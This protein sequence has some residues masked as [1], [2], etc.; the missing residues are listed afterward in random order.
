MHWTSTELDHAFSPPVFFFFLELSVIALNAPEIVLLKPKVRKGAAMR[1]PLL[2]SILSEVCT[3][4]W[5]LATQTHA[6]KANNIQCTSP[7]CAAGIVSDLMILKDIILVSLTL[8]DMVGL[9]FPP[10]IIVMRS[11]IRL[12]LRTSPGL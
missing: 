5:K 9:S 3:E 10:S 6:N 1:G 2:R 12:F 8:S 7:A 4:Q 11:F